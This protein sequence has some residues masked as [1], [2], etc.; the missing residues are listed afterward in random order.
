MAIIHDAINITSAGS[1]PSLSALLG[2]SVSREVFDSVD[3]QGYRSLFGSDFDNMYQDIYETHIR[4]MDALNFE[5]SRTV[6]MLINPDRFRILDSI[7]AYASIPASMEMPILMFEP[8]RTL[9]M[10]GRVEG[11]GYNPDSLPDEDAYGRLI[12]NHTCEDVAAASDDEGYYT[13]TGTVYTDDPEMDDDELY[14]LRRTR[15]FIRDKIL[16]GT[17]RDPTAINYPRG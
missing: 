3:S 6:N 7:E 13:T 10:Q 17:D 11:F 5:M 15:E 12:D 9:F 14:Y 4:P 2:S 8:V 16:S 1:M